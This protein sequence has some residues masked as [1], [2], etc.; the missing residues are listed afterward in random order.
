[1]RS[2][3][4]LMRDIGTCL[5]VFLKDQRT[6]ILGRIGIN[7]LFAHAGINENYVVH[8]ASMTLLFF[9]CFFTI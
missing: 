1:M 9:L 8:D 4:L 3:L 2:Y 7:S 6:M 5:P